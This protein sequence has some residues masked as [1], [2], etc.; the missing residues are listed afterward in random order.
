MEF[1]WVLTAGCGTA[2]PHFSERGKRGLPRRGRSWDTERLGGLLEVP[3][4]A[5]NSLER[6]SGLVGGWSAGATLPRVAIITFK[7]PS[8]ALDGV[9]AHPWDNASRSAELSQ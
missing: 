4:G 2:Q 7:L 8:E 5:G 1:C 3:P 9:L 6:P